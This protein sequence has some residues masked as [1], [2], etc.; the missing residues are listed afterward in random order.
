ME[1]NLFQY[2]DYILFFGEVSFSN[3]LTVKSMLRCFEFVLGLVKLSIVYLGIP[4][5]GNPRKEEMWRSIVEK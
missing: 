2:T 3:V 5:G 4:I 1:V